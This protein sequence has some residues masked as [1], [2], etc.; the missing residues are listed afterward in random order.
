MCAFPTYR[1]PQSAGEP[2][3]GAARV[4]QCM[5]TGRNKP[6]AQVPFST[7]HYQLLLTRKAQQWQN[8]ALYDP[9][10]STSQV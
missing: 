10:L 3:L 1:G 2:C 7:S 6:D 4:Q 5:W 8:E 9:Y